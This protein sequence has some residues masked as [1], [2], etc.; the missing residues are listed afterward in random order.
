MKIVGMCQIYNELRTGNLHRCLNHYNNICDDLVLLDDASTDNSRTVFKEFTNHIIINREN[1]WE[2]NL[3]TLNKSLL[4]EKVMRLD[5]DWI[6][7]FDCDE[8]FEKRFVKDLRQILTQVDCMSS[9]RPEKIS[10]FKFNW[11]NLWLSKR[12]FR[13]DGNL[14]M[15][16]PPRIWKNLGEDVMTIEIA[17]GLHQ[18]LWPEAIESNWKQLNSNLIHYSSCS[19]THFYDKIVNYLKLH[20]EG[21][22]RSLLETNNIRLCEVDDRWYECPPTKERSPDI[23]GIHHRVEQRLEQEG[24][25]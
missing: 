22:Y 25:I 23:I 11:V 13:I 21:N 20:P 3:E 4:L 17:E 10:A 15:I 24:L 12:W 8:I 9:E 5:P 1:N 19:E 7:S 14:G 2:K 6:V 16:S 18:R